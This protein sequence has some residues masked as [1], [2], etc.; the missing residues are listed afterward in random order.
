[1]QEPSE[2]ANFR[3]LYLEYAKAMLALT[4]NRISDTG[5]ENVLVQEYQFSG[6]DYWQSYRHCAADER[7]IPQP[8]HDSFPHAIAEKCADAFFSSGLAAVIK[9]STEAGTPID[10][11]GL[12]KV[13]PFII[14]MY[15]D[16]PIRYLLRH[17]E[18]TSF[19]NRQILACL[20]R[21]IADWRGE[22]DSEPEIAPIYNLETEIGA[23]KL[24]E[25][26]SI[27]RFTDEEKTKTMRILGGLGRAFDLRNYASAFQVARLRS[28]D[29]G[30][31]EARK[32]QLRTRARKA[33][34]CAVTTLRL[35]KP[36]AIGTLGF[37]RF[38]GPGGKMIAG[39]SSPEDFDLPWTGMTLFRDRYVL[40]H[41][42]LPQFRKLY[43]QLS[44]SDF[45]TWDRLK[46]PLRQ[47]NRSCQREWQEDR[48]LD[49]A[50]CLEGTLL[51]GVSEELSYRLALRAAKLLRNRYSPKRTFE[52]MR[53][54]YNVRSKIVH[55]NET[56]SS[57]GVTDLIDKRMGLKANEFMRQTDLLIRQL[58]RTIIQRVAH[59]NSLEKI[60]K[61]LD[62]EIIESL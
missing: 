18:R 7:F 16:R 23:I 9:L 21:C 47:F 4:K 11:P 31:D 49:Y 2:L 48:V 22:A 29:G 3:T 59:Q 57:V 14:H 1:M 40:Y 54:L 10:N 50:I 46:L 35:M 26:V 61:G 12:E 60:C 6:G 58:F 24:N 56:L 5:Q 34:Q 39:L 42:E 27:V 20:D 41:S 32:Q 44:E 53:C 62:K 28:I 51:S 8:V 25:L 38:E 43:G 33:L 45:K 36:A 13:R 52:H 19:S 15:L 30:F 55:T 37:I 17:F